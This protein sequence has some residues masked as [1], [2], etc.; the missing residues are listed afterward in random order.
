MLQILN[1]IIPVFAVIL[2]GLASRLTGHLT[3]NLTAP[4]NRLVYYLAIPAMI[5]KALAKASFTSHF[6]PVLLAATLVPVLFTAG[7][8]LGIGHLLKLP[9]RQ[10]GTFLQSAFHGNL[11]YI[12]FAVAYYLLGET[13]FTSA[14]ILAGFL[15]LLQNFLAVVSLQ[16]FSPRARTLHQLSFVLKKVA[17]NPVI[18]SALAG[19]LFSL[20]GLSMP[21]V[22]ERT[23]AIIAGM[24]LPLAL[25]VIGASLS[26]MLIRTELKH[27]LATSALK[28]ILLPAAGVFFYLRTGLATRTFLPG[29][30]LLASPTA[31]ITYVMAAEMGGSEE[32]ASAA[33]SFN[34]LLSAATFTF[35]LGLFR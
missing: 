7:A 12:G 11:G 5:F 29:L 21:V 16:L 35:W 27:T 10:M 28:L 13:G 8:A 20:S 19:I 1:T 15:M 6:N 30:I 25:L 31:T 18:L 22:A 9:H 2:L 34:T 4:L 33:V 23:L 24:A 17:L 32:L 3:R 26:P 14:S